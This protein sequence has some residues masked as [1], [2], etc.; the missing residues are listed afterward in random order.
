[1]KRHL[2]LPLVPTL[3]F[4]L[5]CTGILGEDTAAD[6]AAS[7]QDCSWY[8]DQDGDGFGDPSEREVG[9]P[10]PSGYVD[11][12]SDCD[13]QAPRVNP[14]AQEVCDDDDVDEDCN[15]DSDLDDAHVVLTTFYLDS[16]GDGYGDQ[17]ASQDA[18]DAPEDYVDNH[19]DCDDADARISP[20][21]EEICDGGE[22]DEDCD[23]LIDTDDPSMNPDILP[24]WYQDDDADGYGDPAS[25]S[26][27]QCEKPSKY[28][29]N[30]EDCD[31]GD[32][33]VNP[34]ETETCGNGTDDNCDGSSNG[35]GLTGELSLSAADVRISGASGMALGRVVCGVGDVDND[36]QDDVVVSGETSAVGGAYAFYGGGSGAL[37][38]S[39]ADA[40]FTGET[41]GDSFGYAIAG[42]DLT[43]DGKA[44][45]V[46]GDSGYDYSSTVKYTGRVY[47][48]S[49]PLSSSEPASS[50]NTIYTNNSDVADYVGSTV[51]IGDWSGDGRNDLFMGVGFD[52]AIADYGTISASTSKDVFGINEFEGAMDMSGTVATGGDTDG[53]GS[54]DLAVGHSISSATDSGYVYLFT[55][56]FGGSVALKAKADATV[57]G[58][59]TAGVIGLVLSIDG[60]L[61]GD[62]YDDLLIGSEGADGAKSNSGAVYGCFGPVTGTFFAED[63][64][65]AFNGSVAGSGFGAAAAYVG[66][67]NGDGAEDVLVG[68]YAA[69]GDATG[70]GAAYLFRG[71]FVSGSVAAAAADASFLG[72]SGN[73][74]AGAAVDGAGD[75]NGDGNADILIGARGMSGGAG[76]VYIY[77]GGGF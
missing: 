36:G 48:F 4:V 41:N 62:G 31:D 45:V 37:R 35:C 12:K 53:D 5:A 56:E 22:D 13:D 1:M 77:L 16:D 10:R 15:G 51:S 67:E 70:S 11:N 54:D 75:W 39:D 20:E 25:T 2:V 3:G 38:Y 64:D 8:R 27:E 60:D 43:G 57:K 61:N 21:G 42:G 28:A 23:G 33:Q 17:G 55:G 40:A 24:T 74:F 65:Y 58:D 19:D 34:G 6:T 52:Y 29:D 26:K 49:S 9:C 50:A 63:G 72:A 30:D 73:S 14:D 76:Q 18:C 7:A 46:I 66:D 47:L 44:D 69:E 59:S 71:P 32:A 68:A